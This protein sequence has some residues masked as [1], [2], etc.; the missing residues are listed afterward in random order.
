M[1]LF[2]KTLFVLSLL[3]SA[4]L[5]QA[6]TIFLSFLTT[7]KELVVLKLNYANKKYTIVDRA[8]FTL[9]SAGGLTATA[10]L[11]GGQVQVA[12]NQADG[13]SASLRS[14]PWNQMQSAAPIRLYSRALSQATLDQVGSTSK[15]PQALTSFYNLAVL[16]GFK[17]FAVGG[18]NNSVFLRSR[19]SNGNLG[20]GG[21]KL[22]VVPQ[23]FNPIDTSFSTQGSSDAASH[24]FTL[25]YSASLQKYG[26]AWAK[27]GGASATSTN[28]PQIFGTFRGLVLAGELIR[29]AEDGDPL[30]REFLYFIYLEYFADDHA[31]SGSAVQAPKV[32]LR[33]Q[34]LNGEEFTSVGNS[35][36][37]V[38]SKP[39]DILGSSIYFNPFA[40]IQGQGAQAAGSATEDSGVH[41]F[42]VEQSSSCRSSLLKGFH[43]DTNTGKKDSAINS[44]LG[45]SD[46]LIK[47]G[48][49]LLYGL[50]GLAVAGS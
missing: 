23:G 35:V 39:A 1:K 32:N 33:I 27:M 48:N 34:K 36:S 49:V 37:L 45:C 31:L 28:S 42:Y 17:Q 12:W 8:V 14:R 19:L 13:A 47:P 43:L 46:A 29:A 44:L 38:P 40:A 16:P 30:A 15:N 11:S 18:A 24:F 41:V 5:V 10:P 20:G 3:A 6:E 26:F 9:P 22:F 7:D 2:V 4:S 21:K 50:S 25:M